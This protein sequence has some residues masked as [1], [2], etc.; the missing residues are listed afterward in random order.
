MAQTLTS[1]PMRRVEDW[2]SRLIDLSRKNNLLY[3]HKTKRTSLKITSPEAES[4]FKELITSKKP[5]EF[6]LPPEEKKTAEPEKPGYKPAKN[7]AKAVLPEEPKNPLPGQLVSEG[8]KRD[9]LEKI[10]KNLQR[11][12]LLDYR[13]RGVRILYVAFGRL[14]WIDLDKE[15]VS[16]PLLLVPIEIT[17]E[18]MRKPYTMSLPPVEEDVILNPA[19][20][21]KLKVDFKVTLPEPPEDWDEQSLNSY[22]DAVA[23]AVAANGW[24]VEQ[25]V[26]L[27]LFSFYKLVIYKDLEANADVVTQ[28]PIVRAIAGIKD[29]S[30]ILDSLPEEKDVDKIEAPQKTFQ[31]LDADSSQRVSIEYA[32]RGQSFV[33]IGPPGTGKSQ[34][35]ANIIGECIAQGKSVLFVSDKMAAL[36]VVYKRLNEV[37]LSHFCLE[38][39]SSKANKQQ[40]VAELKRALEEHLV[41]KKLPAE[42]DFEKMADYR[43]ALN[44]YVT[45]LHERRSYLQRSAYDVLGEISSLERVPF[46]AVGLSGVALLTP[47]KM[48]DIEELVSQLSK[49]WQVVEE[50]DYPWRGYR[51]SKYNL[52]VRSELLT[53][54]EDIAQ[55]LSQLQAEGASY[56]SKLGLDAPASFEEVNW[57]LSVGKYLFESPTPEANWLTEDTAKLIQEAQEYSQTCEW[58]KTTKARLMTCYQPSIF[59]LVLN[60]AQELI[61][62]LNALNKPLA[63]ADL[64]E[65]ELLDKH[66][67]LLTFIKTTGAQSRK[68]LENVTALAGIYGLTTEYPTLEQAKALANLSVYCFGEDKPEPEWFN[69]VTFEQLKTLVAKAEK[70]YQEYNSIKEHLEQIYTPKLFDLDLDELISRYNNSYQGV[71]RFLSGNFRSDQK[72]IS[73]VTLDGKVPKTV[74]EDLVSARKLVLLDDEI[75]AN[76][77]KV[78]T[79]LGRFYN[80]TSTSWSRVNKAIEATEEINRLSW[81]KPLPENLTKLCTCQSNPSPMVKHLG[82]ELNESINTWE[83]QGKD[84]TDIIPEKL[85]NSDRAITRT[86]FPELEEWANQIERHLIYLHDLTQETIETCIKTPKTYNRLISDLKDAQNVRIKEASIIDERAQLTSKYGQRYQGLDTDWAGILQVLDWAGKIKAVFGD[87]A[88]PVAY[89]ELAA[90][91]PSAAPKNTALISQLGAAQRAISSLANRFESDLLYQNQQL[92]TLPTEVIIER[93]MSLRARVDEL[94]VWIDFKDIKNRFSLRGLDKFFDALVENHPAAPTL[95]DVFKRGALQEW[96]NNLYTQDPKLGQFRRENHEQLIA[97]FKKLDQDLIRLTPNRVI[98]E[99]NSRKPQ[100]III[101]AGDSEANILLKEAA[102]KRRL[103]P[104]RTLLQK[105]PNLLVKL[106]PCLLMSPISVSQFL[107]PESAKFD[108]VLFDEASQIVPEDAIG[109]IYRGKTLVVAG[110]NKQLPPTSFFQKSLLEDYDWD[111]LS[112]EDVEVFDSILDECLGVGL[113]VKTL[114]W[115][116]RSKHEELIAFS[117]NRFYENTLITFPAASAKTDNLGVKLDYVTD[118]IYDRGGKRDNPKEAERLADLVFDHFRRYPNKTLCVITFSIAQMETVQEAIDRRLKDNPEFEKFF[119]EDRLEG[120]FVKNLEN[121]QGDERDVIFFSVGYGR[122]QNGNITMNFGPLNKPGGERR[123]NVAVTRAREKVVLVT[124]IKATDLDPDVK[125][126]G[127]QTLRGYLE[128]A[129]KGPEALQLAKVKRGEF[130]SALDEDIAAEIKKM[131]YQVIPQVGCSGYRIDLGVVDPVNP[132]YYLMGVECDGASY[133]SSNSA[134][135]RD[136]LREQVLRN[137][138]WHIYRVWSPAWV[139]RRDSE[140]KRLKEALAQAHKLQLDN[141]AQK[142][143]VDTREDELAQNTFHK[144]QFGGVEKLGVPYKT[145]PI[146][147]VYN[148]YIRVDGARGSINSKQKNEFH[149]PENHEIQTRLLQELIENEGPIHLDYAVERLA[150]AWGVE[151]VTDKVNHAVKAALNTLIREQKA[152]L[153]GSFIWPPMLKEVHIRVPVEG[154]PESRRKPEYIPPEEVEEAMTKIAKYALGIGEESLISE[155]AKV[156]GINHSVNPPKNCF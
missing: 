140:V 50:P 65:S 139:S 144:V 119:I 9:E 90:Q 48:Q 5:I 143:I 113:P 114:R 78:K 29:E 10:I 1:Q 60:R 118:G 86:S 148:P 38:L 142:P 26:D 11:R 136:R 89:A 133:K 70:T 82:N 93:I 77:E 69:P 146:K 52:E 32:L 15:S 95:V 17:R 7:S 53:F 18:S 61:Q 3:F 98:S 97:D 149:Y 36:E 88:V 44:G 40:V 128:Y 39:H 19:L 56:A 22:L 66:E 62:T 112:D 54:L 83:S 74:A 115:H 68:W 102:K 130:D 59:S 132:G 124:S 57:L 13:E 99:A 92:K 116:Y 151:R 153:K 6:W 125:A 58:I 109:S 71:S 110:D 152:V 111:E 126:V 100:D 101:Q 12:A 94:Q 141:T 33:M 20:Q 145:H 51:A 31:V 27:G 49:V 35:I 2:K 107:S 120:F 134:R 129:E 85:P 96:I 87:V 30:I 76:A 43:D 8:L 67:K 73:K 75:E 37:G 42:H 14:N 137:L 154:I 63:N 21:V 23:K 122:D 81:I 45:A 80:G 25:S 55:T 147:A 105:I 104:I 24:K 138:G 117:N 84:L 28:H 127:V 47:Q 64:G 135:D 41:P 121:V 4:L 79:I 106:K 150:A 91:G 72:E 156:F 103:M 34:T 155:T 16:S 46:I 108:V 123:L 131:G